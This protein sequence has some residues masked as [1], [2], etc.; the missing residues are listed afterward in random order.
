MI[1]IREFHI[2]LTA[3]TFLTR[4]R[5]PFR[6]EW[7]E[8]YLHASLRYFPLVGAIVG[9]FGAL[10]YSSAG[11]IL[12]QSVALV[13]SMA[14]TILLTG[15]FHEDGFAD[16]CDGFGGGQN[17]QHILTIMKD[18]RLGTYGVTGLLF[19]LSVKYLLLIQLD[20]VT[21]AWMLLVGHGLSRLAPLLFML[22]AEYVRDEESSKVKPMVHC[23]GKASFMFA[24]L[25]A[26]AVVVL[27]W[28]GVTQ[29][30][31]LVISF[32]V[33]PALAGFPWITAVWIVS[34]I[35][36]MWLIRRKAMQKIGGYTGDILG[37]SQQM[38]EVFIY[39]GMVGAFQNMLLFAG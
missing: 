13:L 32:T 18:S 9:G 36:G 20:V 7:H 34:M 21:G 23:L 8:E 5:I 28:W 2:F 37:A 31:S 26:A 17:V 27:G 39:L 3:L 6:Y 1:V 4:I 15:A 10:V 35:L 14:S 19:I 25:S 16:V 24:C 29:Y 33:I 30:S 12:P 11:L 22:S 38:S